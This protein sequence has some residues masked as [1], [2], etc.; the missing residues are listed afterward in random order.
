MIESTLVSIYSLKVAFT[1]KSSSK[2]DIIVLIPDS[3]YVKNEDIEKLERLAYFTPEILF[4]KDVDQLFYQ[5]PNSAIL[6]DTASPSLLLLEPSPDHFEYMV[7]DYKK[8]H[9]IQSQLHNNTNTLLNDKILYAFTG[10]MK[11][12]N[13]HLYNE[14]DWRKHF[15]AV[16]FYYWRRLNN[17]L[18]SFLNPENGWKNK[19]RQNDVCTNYIESVKGDVNQFPIQDQFSVMISTYNPERIEHLSLIIHHLLKSAKVHTVFVTWHNPSLDIPS[20]LYE[21]IDQQDYH[22]LK[23]IKQS[24]DSLNNRFNPVDELKT[25]AVYIMDDDIFIDLK[26]LEFTF[27]VWKSHK[28]SVVGHFPRLHTYNPTTQQ[29][30]YRLIGK[31]PY[32]IVLTKSMFIHSDYL[33]AYTCVLEPKLHEYVDNELNCED[34]GFAMMASGLSH[35]APTY[36]RPSNPLEDFGLTQ[37]ISTN[38]K[39]MPSRATCVSDFITQYWSQK[40]PL[41][42]SY[43]TVIRFA[44]PEILVGNWTRVEDIIVNEQL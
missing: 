27:K 2:S 42:K 28:D 36:V 15:E 25:D 38:N 35:T 34:L 40:D 6:S 10:P 23:V 16:P 9:A 13:F 37:G 29:A 19:N 14:T 44:K 43:D 17:D 20:S 41:I 21:A 22:R 11:P 39:H 24:Y 30:T 26:D 32:T 18:N 4:N 8:S 31:A 12:W 5:L 33:F 3:V 1:K 7:R